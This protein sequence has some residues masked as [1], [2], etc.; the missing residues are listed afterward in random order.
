MTG[1]TAAHAV[2]AVEAVAGLALLLGGGFAF[3]RSGY[4]KR[5]RELWQEEAEAL[6]KRLE[7]VEAE[8]AALTAKIAELETTLRVLSNQVT[9]KTAVDELGRQLAEQNALVLE[10]MNAHVDEL[11]ER[12]ARPAPRAPAKRPT[13]RARR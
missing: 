7:T 12:L 5:T 1:D 9:G 11:L 10:A 13:T 2:A 6:G 3:L 4:A 8:K